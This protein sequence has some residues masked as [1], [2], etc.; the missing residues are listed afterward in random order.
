[1][2]GLKVTADQM[3]TS[4]NELSSNCSYHMKCAQQSLIQDYDVFQFA[5]LEEIGC[6]V[7]VWGKGK[8]LGFSC[9]RWI[10]NRWVPHIWL[11]QCLYRWNGVHEVYSPHLE[12]LL[13]W[14]LG[15]QSRLINRSESLQ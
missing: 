14:G 13:L 1:M 5:K 9:S 12:V 3:I 11:I 6:G 4:S 2:L 7:K 10:G 15:E 8:G